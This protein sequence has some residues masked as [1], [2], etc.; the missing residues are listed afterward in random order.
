MNYSDSFTPEREQ[1]YVDAMKAWPNARRKEFQ[2]LNSFQPMQSSDTVLDVPSM[3]GF[4]G[5]TLRIDCDEV[6]FDGYRFGGKTIDPCDQWSIGQYDSIICLAAL[7]HI[8]NHAAFLAECAQHLNPGGLLRVADPRAGSGP[9]VFLD[10]AIP[11][12]RGNYPAWESMALPPGLRLLRWRS[13]PCSWGFSS[14]ADLVAFCRMLFNLHH[15]GDAVLL[16]ML[17]AFVGISGGHTL[18]WR[19][20]YAWLRKD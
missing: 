18:Q 16:Q 12:H 15:L 11:G 8:E 2:L 3:G 14:T 13:L 5:K 20:D 9:A 1:S 17:G 7:H 4:T 19:L 6:N 10:M